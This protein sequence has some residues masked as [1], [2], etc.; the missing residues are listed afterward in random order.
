MRK[1]ISGTHAFGAVLRL[2]GQPL[3]QG[4]WLGEQVPPAVWCVIA[5]SA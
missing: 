5:T 1:K 4:G 3:S 2:R